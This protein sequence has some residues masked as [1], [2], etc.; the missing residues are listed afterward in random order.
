MLGKQH[1]NENVWLEEEEE[2]KYGSGKDGGL[3]Y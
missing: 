3:E 1:E 2:H